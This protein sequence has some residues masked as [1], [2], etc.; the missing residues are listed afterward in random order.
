MIPSIDSGNSSSHIAP[1]RVNKERDK[2]FM[3]A[4]EEVGSLLL[5]EGGISRSAYRRG[6]T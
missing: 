3:I 2:H 5:A 6:T 4:L 1:Y